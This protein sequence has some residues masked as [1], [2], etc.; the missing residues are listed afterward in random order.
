MDAQSRVYVIRRM[1]SVCESHFRDSCNPAPASCGHLQKP[2]AA[3]RASPL[4]GFIIGLF[5][6]SQN[7]S[8]QP[9]SMEAEFLGS[10]LAISILQLFAGL[11]FAYLWRRT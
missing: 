3:E 7:L 4:C 1:W 5:S 6:R 10:K 9:H 8:W 2:G 11:Q